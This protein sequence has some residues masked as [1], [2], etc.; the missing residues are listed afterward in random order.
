MRTRS[1]AVSAKLPVL[2][3]GGDYNPE[4]WLKY[5]E[6]LREDL[7]LMKLAGVNALSVGIFSWAALEPEEGRFEFEWLDAVFD[8]LEQNGQKVILATPSGGKPNWMAAK[9]PEIRRVDEKGQ[10]DLQRARHNHCFTSPVYREKATT[11]N[12]K[13]AERYGKHPALVMWHVSNEYSGEC[14]CVLCMEAFRGYLR[15][16]FGT[17]EA[18]NDAYWSR[19]WSHTYTAWEQIEAI[20]PSVHGL[21]LD[22]K[23][24]VTR[25]TNAFL[26]VETAPLRKITPGVPITINMMGTFPGLDYQA[27]AGHVD[28]ISWDSYPAW[29]RAGDDAHEGMRT[30]YMH[31]V[32]RGLKGKPFLLIESTPSHVNWQPLSV[33][34]RPGMHRTAS[35]Q[36]VAHGSDGVLYFQWRKSRGSAEKFHGAVVDHVGHEN[37]RVF[38]DVATVGADLAKLSA[39]PNG[40]VTG[41]STPAEVGL[42][43]DWENRWAIDASQQARNE[44]KDYEPTVQAHYKAFWARGIPVDIVAS[45]ADFAGY[46]VVV[47]PMLYMLRPGVAEALKAFVAGG[48]TLVATYMTGW[49]NENDL[50]HLGGWPGGGLQELFGIWVEELDALADGMTQRV[51]AVD[52]NALGLMGVYEARQL[53]EVVH[54]RGATAAATFMDEFY[55]GTPAVTVQTYG[56]GRAIYVA[57]RNNAEFMDA[58]GAGLRKSCE[59]RGTFE[60]VA[61]PAGISATYRSDGVADYVFVMNFSRLD[62][63]VKLDAATYHDA[64]DDKA[65][66]GSVTLKA[67]ETRVLTRAAR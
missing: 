14:H 43:Y 49:T 53:A 4:Q 27:M 10:R 44:G 19:F 6:V 67:Y 35:L 21:V 56:K 40:G 50:V 17:L 39:G 2:W 7:R 63:T 41:M 55:A 66:A 12:T 11:I 13:L 22:W 30:A 65:V 37:T 64:L 48:G 60:N 31:D 51:R 3:H 23:R 58:L 29:H 62:Q 34:K 33:P 26:E 15:E 38:Q 18:L 45:T 20:D 36:A 32:N 28:V 1:A 57:S 16:K 52:G 42:I 59:L 5:P 24:F 25:Q 54:L 61:L 9:Y 46:K 47:A 8:S